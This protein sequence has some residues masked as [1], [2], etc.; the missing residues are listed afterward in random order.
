MFPI[1]L[2]QQWGQ[3]PIPDNLS[4]KMELSTF[5]ASFNEPER[6]DI[7]ARSNG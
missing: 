5:A 3:T 6:E 7:L 2:R 1:G 4:N